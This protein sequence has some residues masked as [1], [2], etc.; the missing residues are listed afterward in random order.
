MIIYSGLDEDGNSIIFDYVIDTLNPE[1]SFVENTCLKCAQLW[2][3]FSTP[4]VYYGYDICVDDND[5]QC[6]MYTM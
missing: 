6:D 4:T 5:Y 2:D 1:T 3:P